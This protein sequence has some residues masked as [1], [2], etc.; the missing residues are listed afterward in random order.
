MILR[1][2]ISDFVFILPISSNICTMSGMATAESQS[3]GSPVK[4]QESFDK[5]K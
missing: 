1:R 5:I 3:W 2:N 4:E